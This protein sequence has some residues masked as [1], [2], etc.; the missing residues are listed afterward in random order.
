MDYK[1]LE[2]VVDLIKLNPD[3]KLIYRPEIYS[4]IY[5]LSKATLGAKPYFKYIEFKE[6]DITDDNVLEFIQD[7]LNACRNNV[8]EYKGY[9]LLRLWDEEPKDENKDI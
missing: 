4:V 9:K 6:E 8:K 7:F 2:A 3:E 5:P 1:L